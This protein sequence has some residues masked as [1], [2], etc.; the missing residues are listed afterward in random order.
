MP[1]ELFLIVFQHVRI[2]MSFF[3]ATREELSMPM[4]A[5]YLRLLPS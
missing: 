3:Y 5:P 2:N 1:E 4:K